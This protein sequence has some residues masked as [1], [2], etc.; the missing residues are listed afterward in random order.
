MQD[1]VDLGQLLAAAFPDRIAR[2]QDSGVYRFCSGREARLEGPLAG[3]EWLA[4]AEADAGERQGIIRLAAP[5]TKEEALEAL[6]GRLHTE[7]QIQWKGL[8]PRTTCICSAGRLMI[9]KRQE[10][11][12][13]E[14]VIRGLPRLLEEQGLRILPWEE[15]ARRLLERL[16]FFAAHDRGRNKMEWTD[17]VLIRDSSQWLGPFVWEGGNTGKGPILTGSSLAQAL[18]ARLGWKEKQRFDA[19]VPAAFTLANGRKRP[20]DYGSGEPVLQIRLQEA[21]GI[22]A[23]PRILGQPLVFCLLS[24]ANRPIQITRDLAGFWAGSYADVRK[25]MRGRYPKHNWPEKP[26]L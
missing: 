21:F 10:Q 17:E 2:R 8:C 13:R 3:E 25:D 19:M 11:S 4:V 15:E 5:I 12:R 24:P 14:E 23:E 22:K 18:G 1:E 26:E 20:L 16:R 6:Q 9:S 7:E